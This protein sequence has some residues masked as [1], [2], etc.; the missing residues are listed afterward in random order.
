MGGRDRVQSGEDHD[1]ELEP[2]CA[3]H[4]EDSNRGIVGLGGDGL[5]DPGALVGLT[6]RPLD[7][8]TEAGLPG[9]FPASSLVEEE[10]D[11]SPMVPGPAM[12]GGQL[13]EVTLP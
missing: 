5:V 2:F 8:A 12:P 3:V 7:E 13:Q 10:A 6:A 1:R 4:G 9:V 11:P